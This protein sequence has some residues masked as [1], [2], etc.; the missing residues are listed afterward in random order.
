[1]LQI[2]LRE[3]TD[4]V[5][6]LDLLCEVDKRISYYSH[7]QMNNVELLLTL[8][9]DKEVMADL[10]HYKGILTNKL[11]NPTYGGFPLQTI[12]SRVKILINK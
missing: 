3:C 7:N 6:L 2:R 9:Y 1:M 8:P 5:N 12:I 4:C 11:F 10:L